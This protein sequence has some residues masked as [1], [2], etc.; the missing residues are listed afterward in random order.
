M[1]D[2]TP[3]PGQVPPE[4]DPY[5]A[6]AGET[7]APPPPASQSGGYQA[8]PPPP[9]VGPRPAELLDR[10]LARL[11]DL[12]LLV[13]VNLIVV[14]VVIVGVILGQGGASSMGYGGSF[15]AS[16]VTAV[17]GTIIYLGYFGY[18]E[19]TQGKTVGKMVMKLHVERLGGGNPTLEEAIKRNIWLGFGILGIVPILGGVISGIGQLVAVIMIAV[20]ISN[21]PERRPWTDKFAGTQVIKEG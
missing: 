17:L 12:V 5:G 9:P 1:S 13:V 15:V 20:G 3:P 7:P 18:M 16:A 11:I 19:S 6:P 14:S 10:F 2:A 4:H 21:D 8:A